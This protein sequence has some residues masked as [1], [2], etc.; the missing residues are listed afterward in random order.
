MSM[1]VVLEF[2]ATADQVDAVK[3]LLRTV[4]PDTRGYKASKVSPCIRTTTT[5]LHF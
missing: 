4:L 1:K 3:D 5:R 2:Q